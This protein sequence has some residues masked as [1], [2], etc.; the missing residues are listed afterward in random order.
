MSTDIDIDEPHMSGELCPLCGHFNSPPADLT[1]EHNVAWVWDGQTEP[2][3]SGR[4]LAAEWSSLCALACGVDEDS[5][6]DIVLRSQARRQPLRA[7]IVDLARKGVR[8]DEVLERLAEAIPGP[9]WSTEGM[10]SGAGHSCY[11]RAPKRLEDLAVRCRTLREACENLKITLGEDDAGALYVSGPDIDPQW[12]LAIAGR[13]EEGR[14]HGGHVAY[15][16]TSLGGGNWLM[17]SVQRNGAL[18]GV[19]QED[20]DGGLLNDDQIQA[21]W[22]MTLEEAQASEYTEIAAACNG[23]SPDADATE[24]AEI[25]YRAVVKAGGLEVCEQDGDGLLDD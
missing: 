21:M 14:Y 9:G 17:Q 3:G 1:C 16:V 11:V 23:A 24:V 7:A 22:G 15:Y 25:L 2:L 13:W 6:E 10:L 19:T 4:A 12:L 5:T 20:V 8:F 18:D